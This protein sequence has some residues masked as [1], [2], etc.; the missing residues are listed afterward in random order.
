[1]MVE[2]SWRI[3]ERSFCAQRRRSEGTRNGSGAQNGT[4]SSSSS[5]EEREAAECEDDDETVEVRALRN[6]PFPN[7]YLTIYFLWLYRNNS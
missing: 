7:V 3:F 2:I 5:D 6:S 1:M 4:D